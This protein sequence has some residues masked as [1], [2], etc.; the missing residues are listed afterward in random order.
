MPRYSSLTLIT[1]QRWQE[2]VDMVRQELQP[3]CPS[4]WFGVNLIVFQDVEV[5]AALNKNV[6]LI[7]LF[8]P[9][10]L[11]FSLQQL[12]EDKQAG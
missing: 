5:T 6:N 1:E 4:C 9:Q 11:Q 7:C 12:E 3:V 10:D 8:P 2:T